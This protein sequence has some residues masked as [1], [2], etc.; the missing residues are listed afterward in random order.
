MH[1]AADIHIWNECNIVGR[2][3]GTANKRAEEQIKGAFVPPPSH[4]MLI[5]HLRS[6]SQLC[7]SLQT[8]LIPHAPV[9][10]KHNNGASF[11][12]PETRPVDR[13]CNACLTNYQPRAT[14]RGASL[15]CFFLLPVER[16][17]ALPLRLRLFHLG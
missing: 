3:T 10:C 15:F 6:L 16:R 14:Q 9:V 13:V 7:G 17:P 8:V 2:R 11:V 5:Q 1:D 4:I 12:E